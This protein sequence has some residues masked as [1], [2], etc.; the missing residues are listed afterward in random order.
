MNYVLQ[1]YYVIFFSLD[2]AD[3]MAYLNAT[4]YVAEITADTP[5]G[6]PVLFF[7]AVISGSAFITPVFLLTLVENDLVERTFKFSNGRNDQ[8][9]LGLAPDPIT[10]TITIVNQV[11]Y[12]DDPLNTPPGAPPSSLTL[13]ATFGMTITLVAFDTAPGTT[14]VPVDRSVRAF[15]TVNPPPGEHLIVSIIDCTP[16]YLCTAVLV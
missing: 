14:P 1:L 3:Y 8:Q 2:P 9:Y 11:V 16:F 7:S 10:N 6:T 5:F 13:P 12:S 15:V 4:T